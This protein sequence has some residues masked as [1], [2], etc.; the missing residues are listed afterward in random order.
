MKLF[1]PLIIILGIHYSHVNAQDSTIERLQLQ[2]QR[3]TQILTHAQ[4]SIAGPLPKKYL[5]QLQHKSHH[6]E[7]QVNERSEKALNRLIKQEKRMQKKLSKID[8]VAAKN[9]FTESLGKLSSLKSGLKDKIPGNLPLGGNADLDTLLNSMKFLE[10]S[11]EFE[12][13]LATL[14]KVDR[15]FVKLDKDGKIDKSQINKQRSNS[16]NFNKLK[17]L[18][19]DS[20]TFEVE[21]NN[22]FDYKDE[23]GNVKTETMGDITLDDPSLSGPFSPTTG[24]TGNMGVTQT[25]GKEPQKYNSVNKNVKITINS[26]LSKLGAAQVFSHEGYGHA[27]LYKMGVP[28]KH[29]VKQMKEQNRRLATEIKSSIKETTENFKQ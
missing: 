1:I 10:G 14:N 22:K 20:K 5:S 7:E 28:H 21:S 2:K 25:P 11:K 15:A 18:V 27:Y 4:D 23:N 29:Q 17:A 6:I 12:M 9:I 19:N 3:V 16:G 13:I 26:G 8:S 24:E